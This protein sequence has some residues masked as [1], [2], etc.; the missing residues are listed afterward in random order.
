MTNKAGGEKDVVVNGNT[1]PRLQVFQLFIF[2]FALSM[3]SPL[4][5]YC[6]GGGNY[7]PAAVPTD[8]SQ[9]QNWLALPTGS[10]PVD[11]FLYIRPRTATTASHSLL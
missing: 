10:Q 6:G 1:K 8:Y 2:V 9:K 5:A 7:T 4:A 11:V 3:M